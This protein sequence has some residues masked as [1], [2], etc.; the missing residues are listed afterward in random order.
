MTVYRLY[1]EHVNIY[2][3]EKKSNTTF[4]YSTKKTALQAYNEYE[5]NTNNV[6]IL[7]EKLQ[8]NENGLYTRSDILR[9]FDR[10]Y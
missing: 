10:T 2:N 1:I 5:K 4:L 9:D 6:Y 7:L 3:Q 8:P